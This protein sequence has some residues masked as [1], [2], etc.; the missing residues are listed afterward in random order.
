MG[1]PQ[2]GDTAIENSGTIQSSND[3]GSSFSGGSIASGFDQG[4]TVFT[5]GSVAAEIDTF[6]NF[7][8]EGLFK[9]T[10]T[11]H[12]STTIVFAQNGTNPGYFPQSRQ[13]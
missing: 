9:A 7:V 10:G 4:T 2:A 13:P 12:T 6:G 5:G 11:A 8:N 3:T 1:P